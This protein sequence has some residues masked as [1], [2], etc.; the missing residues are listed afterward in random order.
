MFYIRLGNENHK[1]ESNKTWEK[2]ELENALDNAWDYY[3]T[4]MLG[5][6]FDELVDWVE[7]VDKSNGEIV[8][9]VKRDYTNTEK[10]ILF[11]NEKY[12]TEALKVKWING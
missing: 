2:K 9:S 10:P 12:I 11:E 6:D 1:K 7:V 3:Y 8:L 4:D 5:D